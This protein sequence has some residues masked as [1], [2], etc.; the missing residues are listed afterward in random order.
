MKITRML[1]FIDDEEK[2]ELVNAILNGEIS[3]EHVR[4]HHLLPFLN[5]EDRTKLFQGSLEGKIEARPVGFL[6]F[7]ERPEIDR[8]VEEIKNNTITTMRLEEVLP[9]MERDSIKQ[10]FRDTLT[11]IKTK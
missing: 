10:L 5:K 9:F 1:P 11:E 6:P 7:M 4:I 2:T 8:V 3:E